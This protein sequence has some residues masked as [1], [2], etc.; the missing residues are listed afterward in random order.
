MLVIEEGGGEPAFGVI[1]HFLGTN[2]KLDNLFVVGDDGSMER[3]VAV[4]FW[5]GNV[6]FEA[7]VHRV[8]KR[9][10]DAEDEVAGGSVLDDEAKS[11][12]VVNAVD[13]LVVFS[14]LFMKRI[15]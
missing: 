7:T 4:L 15:D 13:V 3:L 8:E 9:M 1:V 6:V 10:D 12:D 11:D 5:H 2:L 14:E